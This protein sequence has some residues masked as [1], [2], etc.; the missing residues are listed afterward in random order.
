ME[1]NH[2][3]TDRVHVRQFMFAGDARFTLTSVKTGTR[4]T[5]RIRTPEDN[6]TPG[7]CS[8]F[9][10]LLTGSDNEN[11]YSY[12]GQF[13]RDASSPDNFAGRYQHGKKSK[14]HETAASAK[15]FVWFVAQLRINPNVFD[16]VEFRHEGHCGRCGKT[17]TTPESIDTGFGPECSA[18]LGITWESKP[19]SDETDG[20]E[21][22]INKCRRE[23]KSNGPFPF[24]DDILDMTR[25]AA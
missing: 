19:R 17:L 8:H 18:K 15:A 1:M 4:F 22:Y 23:A 2:V 21:D 5:Y 11:S 25:A 20:T 12:L 9:V 14:I 24:D 6:G 13:Y 16:H 3:M 7:A 10:A